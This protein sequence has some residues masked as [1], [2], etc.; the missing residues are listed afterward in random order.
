MDSDNRLGEFLRARR[1]RVLP[2]AVGLPGDDRPRRVPG[3]RREELAQLAGVSTNYIVRLEQGRDRH[4]SPS[5]LDALAGALQLDEA[6]TT[7]LHQL[8]TPTG[9]RPRASRRRGADAVS[10]AVERLLERLDGLPVSVMNRF[11]DV[12]ATTPLAA[13]LMPG[14]SAGVNAYRATFLDP[15]VRELFGDGWDRIARS[16]VAGLHA[17]SADAAGDPRLVDLVGELS[18]ESEVFRRL[19]AR[20]D[21]RPRVGRGTTVLHH[22]QVGRVELTWEKLEISGSPG[23]TLV[24]HQAEPGSASEQALALLASLTVAPEARAPAPA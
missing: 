21:V 12:L 3:L 11:G 14:L 24:I 19:W 8:G 9:E 13:A 5:V 16:V 7:H 6:A 23:Q 18:L 1:E 2:D 15:G 17:V 20:Y 22:P 4:P 10:P